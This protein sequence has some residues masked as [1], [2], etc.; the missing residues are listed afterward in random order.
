M[1][2]RLLAHKNIRLLNLHK[3]IIIKKNRKLRRTLLEQIKDKK[4]L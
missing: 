1:S 4:S 3:Y 2:E